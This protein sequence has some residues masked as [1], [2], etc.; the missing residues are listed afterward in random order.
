MN[1][2]QVC[3][4]YFPDIG[5][6][7]THVQEISERLV[8]QGHQVEVVCTDP[9]GVH[10]RQDCING[11]QVR[12][13]RSFAPYDAYFIAPGMFHHIK[14][15]DAEI[16]HAHGYHA[17]PALFA[18][19]AVKEKRFIFT[20]HY[21]GKGHTP[22]RNMLLKF[23]DPLGRTIF[24]R[25]DRIICVSGYEKNL[26]KKKFCIREEKFVVIPNG[27]NLSEFTNVTRGK[28][29][30]VSSMSG[31]LKSIKRSSI[32]SKHYQKYRNTLLHLSGK[33]H[34]N[35]NYINWLLN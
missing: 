1:I 14:T 23:Y 34:L 5:G 22:F 25:A 33:V 2:I 7:E 35:Q 16:L 3:P 11:V 10:P 32:S 24:K 18:R 8:R 19:M 26:I 4:R 6:V 15:N 28:I 31:E 9:R 17:F 13:F 27:L 29:P 12:R 30:T 20:P 21:H